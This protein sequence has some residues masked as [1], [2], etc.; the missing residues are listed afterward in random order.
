MGSGRI[1]DTIEEFA[2]RISLFE[3]EASRTGLLRDLIGSIVTQ[4]AAQMGAV[5]VHDEAAGELVLRAGIEHGRFC[6][7]ARCAEG[8]TP[9]RFGLEGNEVG[10]AF[11]EGR[12]ARLTY[13]DG[14]AKHPYRS[15]LLIPIMRGPLRTGVLILARTDAAGF[16]R[17]DEADLLAA[18][19]RF[20]ELLNEASALIASR[21]TEPAPGIRRSVRGIKAS[22]GQAYG[23]ALPFWAD[24][25]ALAA[26]AGPA[27]EAETELAQFERALAL[28][29]RQLG[30]MQDRASSGDFEMVAMIFSAH[31]LMLKDRGFTDKMRR[32][33]QSGLSAVQAVQA[34]VN[35]YA[36]LFSAM[37][38]VRLAEKAQD[39][40]DLGYRLISNL[41]GS[42][43]G[44]FSYKG[45]IAIAR[46]IYPSDLYRLA[47]EGVEGLVLRGSGA[48]AHISILARSLGLPV[49][50]T[51]D[52]SLLA[53][54][55]GTALLLDATAGWLHVDPARDM[56]DRYR[57]ADSAETPE[58]QAY[59][60]RGRTADGVAVQVLANVNILRDALD[61]VTQGAEGIGLYRSEFPFI[62]KNDYL[63]EEQQYRIYRSIVVSQ[64]TRPVIL[65]TADIGGD[66]LLQGR[67]EAESNPFLGVRGIRF[68]L[69]NREMFREQL[70]AMLRAGEGADLGI[71]LPMV[72]G[73]E[74]VLEAKEEIRLAAATLAARGVGHNRAPRIGA[75][76]ELPSAAMAVGDI[77]TETDF[78]SIGTN[79]LTLY[80]LAVDRTNERLSHLYQSHHPA[81]LRVLSAIARFSGK[82]REELSVCGDVASDPVLMP[83]F[84]G[85]GIRKLSVSPSKVESVKRRL[86]SYT[87]AEM[88]AIARELLSLRRLAEMERY[89]KDFDRLH[90]GNGQETGTMTTIGP[91]TR[92]AVV[93]PG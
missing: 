21:E 55:E 69:A 84:V 23:T 42:E 76:I 52:K 3:D 88:Q 91:A 30:T 78:L 85:I 14:D 4:S 77:A 36:R 10:R 87:L 24:L 33:V 45:K 12:I 35:E 92:H 22:D 73:V 50:I 7:D 18:A 48:T 46:H 2:G 8:Q 19:A 82:K 81:V 64:G 60:V 90:P 38:E 6:E 5:F 56:I 1:S 28:S 13:E 59:H 74:E 49:M 17:E 54:P 68:S 25:E 89:L 34:V 83:F 31:Q 80:L 29:L 62:L 71:M 40:R 72:S 15:K 9:L 43:S 11:T 63:S 26:R 51:E 41:V 70:R 47:M 57:A 27:A 65:R 93:T 44:D 39:V 67:A 32:Q 79:D 66:K 37:T 86:A 20:G 58:L 75:M 16:A 61:A 53:I